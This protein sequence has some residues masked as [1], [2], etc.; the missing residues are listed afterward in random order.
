[1][2]HD[3]MNTELLPL[4]ER[5]R[6]AGGERDYAIGYAIGDRLARIARAT[7]ALFAR[8]EKRSAKLDGHLAAGD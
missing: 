4:E 7:S 6:L 1:V 2:A 5:I 3:D 8:R